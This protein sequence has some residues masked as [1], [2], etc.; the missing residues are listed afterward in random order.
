MNAFVCA[1]LG[2]VIVVACPIAAAGEARLRLSTTTSTEASGLLGEI[3]PPFEERFGVKVHVIA[4]GSGKALKL[5][6]NGDVD[7]VLSHAPALEAAFVAAGFGVNRREV[8]YNDFVI[9]GPPEDPAK[10]AG[11]AVAP[12]FRRIGAAGAAFISRGD[13][14]GTHQKEKEVWKAASVAPEGSWYVSAGQGMA[15][16]LLMTDERRAYTLA[17]RA[18][19]VTFRKRGDLALL[20]E[21]DPALLNPYSVIAVNPARHPHVRYREAMQLIDW[22]TSPE[23]QE[24]VGGFRHEGQ[25]LFRPSAVPEKNP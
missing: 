8:M 5:A 18:T 15:E 19:F 16:I 20:V 2:S 12:A 17:D 1:L 10:I 13:E 3:L 21:G 22:L 11:E 24:R 7:V 23:G 4:V 9:V 14:S 25:A 6:E